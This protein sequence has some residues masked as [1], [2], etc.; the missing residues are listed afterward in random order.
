MMAGKQDD[1]KDL[2]WEA[3]QRGKEKRKKEKEKI[4]RP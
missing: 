2:Q 4:H 1:S 3:K